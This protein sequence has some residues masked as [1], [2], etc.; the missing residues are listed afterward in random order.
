MKVTL[1]TGRTKRLNSG[2]IKK[3]LSVEVKVTLTSIPGTTGGG[4]PT[5]DNLAFDYTLDFTL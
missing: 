1:H 5:P 2:G 3:N 4:G